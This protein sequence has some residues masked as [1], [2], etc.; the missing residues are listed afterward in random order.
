MN[1]QKSK[2][3]MRNKI[4]ISKQSKIQNRKNR[5]PNNCTTE[6]HLQ[7]DKHIEKKI[8]QGNRNY[9]DITEFEKKYSLLGAVP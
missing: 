1:T 5:R 9:A 4:K 7:N 8:V 2:E 3:K 6:K